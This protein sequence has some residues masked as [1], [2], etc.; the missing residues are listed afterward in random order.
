MTPQFLRKDLGWWNDLVFQ[1][2]VAGTP[3]RLLYRNPK[4]DD[5]WL[6]TSSV[7]VRS[8]RLRERFILTNGSQVPDDFAFAKTLARVTNTWGPA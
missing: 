5:A 7:Y 6:I 1:S 4:F 8:M 2:E 3:M